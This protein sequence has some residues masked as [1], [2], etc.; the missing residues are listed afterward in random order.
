MANYI[1]VESPLYMN[2]AKLHVE[3]PL[4]M[5]SGNYTPSNEPCHPSTR[6]LA[7]YM[8]NCPLTWATRTMW[9]HNNISNTRTLSN[10]IYLLIYELYEH[11][12]LYP[13]NSIK[14]TCLITPSNKLHKLH[15][16]ILCPYRPLYEIRQT[17]CRIAPLHEIRQTTCQIA[18][19]HEIHQTASNGPLHELCQTTCIIAPLHKPYELRQTMS[20][21]PLTRTPLNYTYNHPL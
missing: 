17:T 1:H 7:N 19:S 20:N 21:R 13:T 16:T 4:Y 3:S 18:P 14:I 12:Q 8:S 9:N 15:Q 11:C 2:S 6:T 5:N 10:Y